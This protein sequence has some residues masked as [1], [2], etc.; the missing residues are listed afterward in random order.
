[1]NPMNRAGLGLKLVGLCALVLALAAFG[2][3]AAQAT[4]MVKGRDLVSSGTNENKELT[5]SIVAPNA[6][7]LA[8]L[9]LNKVAFTCT[10]GT[11]VNA[12]LEP[13][14]AISEANQNAKVEFSGCFTE[15]NGTVAAKC[16]PKATGKIAGTIVTEESYALLALH[17]LSE[18][19]K[20]GVVVIT[21]K[22]GTTFAVIHMGFGCGIGETVEVFGTLALKDSGGNAGLEEEKAIHTVEEFA[23]LTALTVANKESK[24]SATLDGKAEV[25][26][27]S[28]EVWNGLAE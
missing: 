20:D 14:G 7:L 9:G 13:L 21:P 18:T 24:S 27:T 17:K 11:L 1:M 22:V 15:L 25:K 10:A 4:W 8:K 6:K 19:E 3:A 23:P 16:E 2:A 5:G 28:S 12:E 26:L